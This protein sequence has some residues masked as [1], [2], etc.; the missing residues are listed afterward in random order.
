MSGSIKHLRDPG[1][2]QGQRLWLLPL[3]PCA[4]EAAVS[5]DWLKEWEGQRTEYWMGSQ[6]VSEESILELEA[7]ETGQ[8][9]LGR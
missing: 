7:L 1:S 5:G 6:V 9:D 4:W 8:D 2:P 3:Y